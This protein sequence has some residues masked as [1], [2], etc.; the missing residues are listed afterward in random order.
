MVD[1]AFF[2]ASQVDSL[3]I[4]QVLDADK[5]LIGA[6]LAESSAADFFKAPL[7]VKEMPGNHRLAD[8]IASNSGRALRAAL[9]YRELP[10]LFAMRRLREV[11]RNV[12]GSHRG[13]YLFKMI[14]WLGVLGCILF[15]PWMEEV[16]SD[17]TLVPKQRVKVVPEIS[18]RVASVLAREG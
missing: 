5:N 10:I 4:A 8:W 15:F 14:F 2:E 11:K 13:R 7:G 16:E 17:C 18:G 1:A 12:T 3:L 6:L 9:D